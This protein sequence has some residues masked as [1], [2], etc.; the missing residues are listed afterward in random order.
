MQQ[1]SCVSSFPAS[2]FVP[3]L[4]CVIQKLDP[5]ELVE[6]VRVHDHLYPDPVDV[7]MCQQD[8]KV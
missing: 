4:A 7:Y 2:S 8:R 6:R 3:A 5:G 1:A